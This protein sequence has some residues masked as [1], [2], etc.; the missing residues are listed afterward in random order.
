[1][2]FS[3]T[4]LRGNDLSMSGAENNNQDSISRKITNNMILV[5]SVIKMGMYQFDT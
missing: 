3:S 2:N 1:M 4:A 5:K